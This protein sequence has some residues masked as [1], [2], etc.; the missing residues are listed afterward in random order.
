M[1]ATKKHVTIEGVMIDSMARHYVLVCEEDSEPP[2]VSRKLIAEYGSAIV[3]EAMG[4]RGHWLRGTYERFAEVIEKNRDYILGADGMAAILETEGDRQL[5]RAIA[6][7]AIMDPA[8]GI[9]RGF[10]SVKKA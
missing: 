1:T 7:G 5:V 8:T 4:P 2:F 3:T 9:I 6:A 10:D